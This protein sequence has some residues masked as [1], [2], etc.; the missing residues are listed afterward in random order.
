MH[1]IDKARWA[2]PGATLPR[3]AFSL[4]GRIGFKDQGQTACTQVAVF[5]YG[6]TLLV[7]EVRGLPSQKY[8]GEGVGNILHFEAGTVAKGQFYPKGGG[9]SE[10]LPK[11]EYHRG[12]G[13]GDHFAT[14]LAAV[15]SRKREDLNADI[16]EGHYSAALCHLANVSYR[17][18]EPVPF[19]PRTSLGNPDAE[20]ALA[21]MEEHLAKEN[22]LKLGDWKLT[23]GRK[24]QVDASSEKIKGDADANRLLTRE[25]RKPFAVPDKVV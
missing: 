23:V 14:F 18:G 17:L 11:I 20:E 10:P 24:L 22:N 2:I 15:R 7:F 9:K 25:Y 13:G 3:S 6:E 21:R 16:L 4:G 12:P 5:D 19:T 8:Q 1:E